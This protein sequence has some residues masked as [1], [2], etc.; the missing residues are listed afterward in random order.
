MK[1]CRLM[2]RTGA[3][4]GGPHCGTECPIHLEEVQVWTV[5]HPVSHRATKDLLTALKEGLATL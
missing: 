2:G 4:A 1:P 3:V 5:S